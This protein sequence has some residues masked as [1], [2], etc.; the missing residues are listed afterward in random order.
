MEKMTLN[1]CTN[2]EL[3]EKM[4]GRIL[5]GLPEE[6]DKN[7]V[8]DVAA[9]RDEVLALF[10]RSH[11]IIWHRPNYMLPGYTRH[12]ITI[13]P[14]QKGGMDAAKEEEVAITFGEFLALFEN[15]ETKA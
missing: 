3:I 14:H 10:R 11:Y 2:E 4:N 13:N 6:F 8:I 7:Y 5:P 12:K 9:I 15:A 1:G